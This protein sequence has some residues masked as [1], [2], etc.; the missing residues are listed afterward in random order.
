MRDGDLVTPLKEGT[1]V[2][3]HGSL[4]HLHDTGTILSVDDYDHPTVKSDDG[5]RYIIRLDSGQ[6]LYN[7][8]RQ[9]FTEYTDETVL[10]V[11]ESE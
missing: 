3:Y 7:V 9:S 6:P 2:R 10:A 8:R 1:R 4:A 11:P 5:H